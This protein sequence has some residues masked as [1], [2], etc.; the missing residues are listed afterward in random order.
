[1]A[2]DIIQKRNATTYY[3]YKSCL[4]MES[5]ALKLPVHSFCADVNAS[6]ETGILSWLL[7][8]SISSF[9]LDSIQHDF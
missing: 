8:Y 6:T 3:T 1:M 5:H 7:F 9:P 2:Q 4:V